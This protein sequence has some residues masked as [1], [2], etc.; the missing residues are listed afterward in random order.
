MTAAEAASLPALSS[1]SST[2]CDRLAWRV[3]MQKM[4]TKHLVLKGWVL[5]VLGPR[6]CSAPAFA[7]PDYRGLGFGP[8]PEPGPEVEEVELVYLLL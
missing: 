3:K 7:V 5:H 6:L 4:M 2:S 8:E 1:S